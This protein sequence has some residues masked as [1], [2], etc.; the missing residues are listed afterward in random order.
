MPP[1]TAGTIETNV[2]APP[3]LQRDVIGLLGAVTLGVVFLPP[4]MTLYGLFGP[5]FLAAGSAAPLAFIF[6]L[7]ATLPTAFG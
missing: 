3:E 5:I 2:A 6:A 7:A 4:T 1:E